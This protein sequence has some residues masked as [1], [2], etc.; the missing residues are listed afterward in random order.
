M[1]T[2]G[3]TLP[4]Y[5]MLTSSTIDTDCVNAG[6]TDMSCA[7]YDCL[8]VTGT[9]DY[10]GYYSASTQCNDDH[11][12]FAQDDKVLC[13]NSVYGRWLFS[14]STCSLSSVLSA[15]TTGDALSPSYW[16]IDDT[17][18]DEYIFTYS[19]SV[20]IP[21]CG[22]NAGFTSLDCID[23]NVY[24]EEI[25]VNTSSMLWNTQR[26]FTVHEELCANDQPIYE[27]VVYNDSKTEDFG[28]LTLSANA[29]FFIEATFFLHYHPCYEFS[30]D[31][32]KTARWIITKD[33]ITET[34]NYLA[35]CRKEDLMDCTETEWEVV[36][37]SFYMTG[38]NGEM[39]SIIM[40]VLDEHMSV[41]DGP[42]GSISAESV[43]YGANTN[44]I[45]LV[46]GVVVV[47]LVICW[48]IISYF[49]WKRKKQNEQ[50]FIQKEIGN[51]HSFQ[52]ETPAEEQER[53]ADFG[54]EQEVAQ[55]ADLGAEAEPDVE[56]EVT[57][58]GSGHGNATTTAM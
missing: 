44:K 54:D 26:T 42:C 16:L 58:D 3:I 55:G 24:Q 17:D 51:G 35:I 9:D 33:D 12:V 53:S 25:C 6:E 48:S 38:G 40:D 34:I 15:R 10:D 22:T 20:Y 14:E 50:L 56:V 21:D 52:I 31:T 47:L 27:F 11:R 13:Y 5:V 49:W 23:N 2:M 28:N 37:E 7:S 45:K 18:D 39:G 29:S 41:T 43:V 19:S 4:S 8:Y 30:T 32:E 1:I 36:S 46:I 57:M